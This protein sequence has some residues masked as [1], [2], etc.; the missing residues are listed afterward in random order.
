MHTTY[1]ICAVDA[2]TCTA[3]ANNKITF[4]LHGMKNTET[5]MK[6]KQNDKMK[7]QNKTCYKMENK[8]HVCM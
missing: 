7:A 5:K 8:N 2:Y 4:L 6:K 1:V 3:G